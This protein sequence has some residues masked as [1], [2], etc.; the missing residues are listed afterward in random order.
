M[1]LA[2]SQ[3][4]SDRSCAQIE[5]SAVRENSPTALNGSIGRAIWTQAAV[6]S[7]SGRTR[8]ALRGSAWSMAGYVATQLLRAGTTLLLARHFL[9]PEA[10]GVVGLIGAFLAGLAM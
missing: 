5:P 10:F 2:T 6:G 8:L 1:N 4:S 3:D 7:G 9:G